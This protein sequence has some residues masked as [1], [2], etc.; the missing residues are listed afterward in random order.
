MTSPNARKLSSNLTQQNS[1]PLAATGTHA[2]CLLLRQPSPSL[3]GST[4]WRKPF[5][6]RRG[7][8]V[9]E[10]WSDG[11]MKQK[12]QHHSM[13][14]ILPR[15]S[16]RRQA[17][18]LKAISRW[19]SEERATPPVRAK[20]PNVSRGDASKLRWQGGRSWLASLQDADVL[21]T[22]SGGVTSLDHRLM[23]RNPSGSAS[24]ILSLILPPFSCLLS[25]HHF[26]RP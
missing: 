7:S 12:T 20:R 13:E 26:I 25:L 18:G 4:R 16:V 19:L 23:A 14:S 2:G 3:R 17:G 15:T 10:Y 21:H 5:M 1:T 9:M 8:G 24:A 6:R 22:L 11:E